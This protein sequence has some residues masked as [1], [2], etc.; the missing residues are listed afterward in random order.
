MGIKANMDLIGGDNILLQQQLDCCSVT[1]FCKLWKTVLAINV[2]VCLSKSVT[3]LIVAAFQRM[4][5]SF[6]LQLPVFTTSYLRNQMMAF[7]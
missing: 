7:R 3:I 4:N 5:N 6:P 2:L 1:P